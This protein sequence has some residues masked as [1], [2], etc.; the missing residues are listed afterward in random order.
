M[1]SDAG[2]DAQLSDAADRFE[3]AADRKRSTSMGDVLSNF[4]VK[5]AC[6][7]L[8][9][10]TLVAAAPVSAQQYPVKPV[11]IIVP[12]APGEGNDLIARFLAQ[13]LTEGLAQ[14]FFVENKMTTTRFVP[15]MALVIA[16]GWVYSRAARSAHRGPQDVTTTYWGSGVKW[17][18]LC[19]VQYKIPDPPDSSFATRLDA[20]GRPRV[21]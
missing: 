10:A 12:Y 20:A 2:S 16:R 21:T 14:Q 4:A 9:T 17:I 19:Y 13:R 3:A 18:A 15:A 1:D 8:A 6:A 5:L 7:A 11:K